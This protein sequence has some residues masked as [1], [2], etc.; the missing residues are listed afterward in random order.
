[1]K[2]RRDEGRGDCRI[3]NS[4]NGNDLASGSCN[5]EKGAVT[6]ACKRGTLTTLFFV[7]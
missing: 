5:S 1:M 6:I 7:A 4:F 3:R 2:E